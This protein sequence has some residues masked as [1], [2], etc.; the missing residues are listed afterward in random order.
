M[1]DDSPGAG[2]PAP[3]VPRYGSGSLADLAPSVLAALGVA[4][5]ENRLG[6]PPVRRA[7]VLLVDGLG[8]ELLR[9]HPADAP[10]LTALLADG[11]RITA[12][13]PTTTATS[14]TSLGTG[15]PPG[16]HGVFGYQVALPGSHRPFNQLRWNA[17]VDPERWQ[18]HPTAFQRAEAA[19]VT[20]AYVASGLFEGS[21]LTRASA[22]GGRYRQAN[23]MSE[24]VVRAEE[25]LRA[26]DRGYVFVYHPDL[27]A[28]GH[29]FGSR[30][31]N[32]RYHLGHVDRLVEQ[33]AGALPPD[34]ALYV[35]GD[36]GMVDVSGE[37]RLDIESEPELTA[38]VRV[39]AGEPRARHVYA[40]PG[41]AA[42][43]LAAW[44][45]R[46]AGRAHVL[47][48]EEAV[49]AGW[50]G[51]VEEEL[52]PRIGDVVAAAYGDSALV[53]PRAEAAESALVGMHGSLTE[54]ELAVPLLSAA[55]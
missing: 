51:P 28:T 18:P 39:L 14:L 13:F 55:G 15:R 31:P 49:A 32:W 23:D 44:R 25:A 10:F 20:T 52:A 26:A 1:T 41:A 34:S 50:F 11:R 9:S 30:S 16:G 22:R 33:L 6:L 8:W 46:L 35:T 42:D 53:A 38:G 29:L 2:A 48:R 37:G 17:D 19:G 7:C 40:E 5:E 47:G 43:V 3:A 36:H 27:D 21:G 4:G 54:E 24:L 45:A 12:G